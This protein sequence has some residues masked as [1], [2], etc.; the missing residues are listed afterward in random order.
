ML[1]ALLRKARA[2]PIRTAA[3]IGAVVGL[4]NVLFIELGAPFTKST[5]S[6]IMMLWPASTLGNTVSQTRVVQT[7]MVLA[8]ELIANVLVYAIMFMIPVTLIVAVR[9]AFGIRPSRIQD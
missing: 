2:H 8:V 4:A 1:R 3:V 7:V 9:R 5:N 6:A